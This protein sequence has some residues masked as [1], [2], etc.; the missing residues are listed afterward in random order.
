MREA[1]GRSRASTPPLRQRKV[2]FVCVVQVCMSAVCVWN[3]LRGAHR[4]YYAS[5]CMLCKSILGVQPRQVH[6]A[7]PSTTG[8]EEPLCLDPTLCG[9]NHL[10]SSCPPP[11]A[12]LRSHCCALLDLS[13]RSSAAR[14]TRN[15]HS[16]TSNLLLE[17]CRT[18]KC[19]P[20]WRPWHSFPQRCFRT[21]VQGGTVMAAKVGW[22]G[23]FWDGACGVH[24][25]EERCSGELLRLALLCD[26]LWWQ[27]SMQMGPC[28]TQHAPSMPGTTAV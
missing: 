6:T 27:Y 19:C 1:R 24:R 2:S 3:I 17:R 10:E 26:T 14:N 11:A 25:E 21:S 28:D 9:G 16:S 20:R 5:V 8:T 18:S 7:S 15:Q 22:G 4:L 23:V 12:N 13:R